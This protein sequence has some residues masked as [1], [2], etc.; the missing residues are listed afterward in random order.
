MIQQSDFFCLG[1]R[2][3]WV[4]AC[5][6]TLGLELLAVTTLGSMCLPGLTAQTVSSARAP[7]LTHPAIVLKDEAGQSVLETGKAISTRQPAADAEA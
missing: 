1:R 7:K 3:A 6:A 5:N 4:R 2:G